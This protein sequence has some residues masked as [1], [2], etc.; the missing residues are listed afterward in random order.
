MHAYFS[1]TFPKTKWLP[2]CHQHMFY[3]VK[4]CNH[5]NLRWLRSLDIDLLNYA[6]TSYPTIDQRV[7]LTQDS[8]CGKKKE[9][10]HR[11]KYTAYYKQRYDEVLFLS[12]FKDFFKGITNQT[13]TTTKGKHLIWMR[14]WKQCIMLNIKNKLKP[15]SLIGFLL[16]FAAE[17]Y[18]DYQNIIGSLFHPASVKSVIIKLW[19]AYIYWVITES[20]E[21]V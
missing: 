13:W 11:K 20:C 12:F 5:F 16:A 8:A 14:S 21:L 10:K 15:K 2:Y 6:A 17:T 3:L 9:P 4:Q 1:F 18:F 19:M 7:A